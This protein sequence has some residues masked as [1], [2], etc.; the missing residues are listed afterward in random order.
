MPISL[1]ARE[2]EALTKD[3]LHRVD[4]GLYLQIRRDGATRSWLLRYRFKGR[5]KWMGLGPARVLTL[6][7][8]KRRALASQRLILDGID[9]AK[10]RKAERRPAAMTFAECAK[11]Y[12]E[13]H[14]A[15]W[16]ND[17][18]IA[19]WTST[20]DTYANPVIGKLP[21]DQVDADHVFKILEPIWT[22]KTE[23]ATRL[24]GRLERVLDWARASGFR[25]GENPARWK[26]GLSHRLPA[27]G[28]VQRKTAHHGAVPYAEIPALMKRLGELTSILRAQS[29][30][31]SRRLKKAELAGRTVVLKL[32]TADFKIRTRNR[33]LGDPTR[34]ADRIFRTGLELLKRETDGTRYRLLGIGV[35]DLVTGDSAD[36]P[37]LVDLQARKRALAEGAFDKVREKFGRTALETGYTFGRQSRP[38]REEDV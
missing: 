10:A 24:R 6:T 14:K 31:V 15:G 18:H 1:T 9:P 3:G 34:L 26:G 35:S 37:D 5:P 2:V 11:K 20:L 21:V 27:P 22:T 16:K 23:T 38:Q 19:Q 33:Q 28:K 7:E 12:V 36:P 30:K 17:K 25:T 29:E 8:A 13:T 4:H 32:K